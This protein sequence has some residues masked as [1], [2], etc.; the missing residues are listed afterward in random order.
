MPKN[1]HKEENLATAAPCMFEEVEQALTSNLVRLPAVQS[2]DMLRV[3]SEVSIWV[4][5]SEDSRAIRSAIYAVEDDSQS[6]SAA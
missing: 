1:W 3:D 5:V 2:V 4:G 6:G